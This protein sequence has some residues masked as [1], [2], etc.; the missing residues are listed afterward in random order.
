[1]SK[2]LKSI[3]LFYAAFSFCIAAKAADIDWKAF[4]KRSDPVWT[5]LPEKFDHGAFAG[6]GTLGLTV[7]QENATAMRFAMGRN[8]VTSHVRDNARLQM[9]GLCLA[10]KGKITDGEL[11][12]NLWDAEIHGRIKTEAGTV[13]FTAYV[14]EV[15]NTVIIDY[16]GT[17]GE[18]DCAWEWRPEKAVCSDV[19]YTL[20]DKPNPEWTMD[21]TGEV[22]WCEQKR[23]AGGS[24]TAAWTDRHSRILFT[25]ADTFPNDD[26]RQTAVETVKR[27]VAESPEALLS[28]HRNWWHAYY[29]KAFLS[30]PDSQIEGF[31]WI[32]MYKLASA[33]RPDG[34][35]MDLQGPWNRPTG[36]P[37]IWWNLNIQIAYSPVYAANRLELGESFTRFIDA[38][39]DAFFANAKEIWGFDDCAT[40]PHT[41]SYDARNGTGYCR[42]KFGQYI[43][44]GDFTWAL[45]VYWQQYRYSMDESLVNDHKAHAFYP[46][47]KGSVNLYLRLLQT[48]SDGKLHLPKMHSPE[49][50]NAADNN[51]N[52]S[53]LRWGCTTL[54]SLNERYGI[55]DSQAGD[56]QRVLRDLTPYPQNENGF[57]IGADVP[58]AHSHRHWSHML[59]VWPLHLLSCEQP[60]NKETVQKT[61]RHWLNVD[62]GK[63]IWGWSAAAS[64]HLYAIMGDGNN[65]VKQLRSHHNNKH[66]VMPNTQY[67][68]GS[69]VYECSLVAASS[70]QYMLLQSWGGTIRVFPSVPDEWK[71]ASF[72]NLRAEGAFLVS[73][74]R[75]D[76]RTAWVRV[77]SL[78]GEPCR[79]K[80]NFTGPF[81]CDRPASLKDLGNGV[82]G[83][84]LR[85][86]ESIVLFQ[87]DR[88]PE[89]QPCG[90]EGQPEN[91][92]GVKG[93][94]T[95]VDMKGSL[96]LGKRAAEPSLAKGPFEPTD[97]SLKHYQ[98]PEWFRDAKFGIWAVWGPESVPMHGDWYARRM[99][100]P[101]EEDNEHHL[102]HYGHPSKFGFK[103]IIPLWKAENWN[104]ERLMKL[105]QKAGAKYF[106]MIA[107]HHD[108]FDCWN[109]TFQRW[110]AVNMGPRR[111]IAGEWQKAAQNHG[112][113]FGMTEHLAASWWF[114]SPAKGS[115][116]SEP[117]AGVPYDGADPKYADLYWNGNEKPDGH[118]YLPKAPAF[119]KQIWFNRIKDMVDRYHPDLLY[120]DSPL[121]YPGEFGQK[122][123]A[124]YYNDNIQQ[125]GGKLEAVYNCKQDSQGRW[126]QDLER[127]VMHGINPNPW[128]TDTCVGNWYYQTGC[129]YKSPAIILQMLADI[130]AKNG[131]LLLN[132]PPRP[133]GTLDE[134][135][136]KILAELAAWMPINGEAIFGTRPWPVYGEGP[137]KVKKGANFN[138]GSLKYTARDIRFTT[139]GD[140]LY[141]LA[142]GWPGDG[143]IVVQSLAK[144]AGRI[145][146]VALLGCKDKL[147]WS[148]TDEGLVVT[149][150]K[151]KP[152]E[153]VFALKVAGVNIRPAPLPADLPTVL[154][155]D[156]M[157]HLLLAGSTAEIK[158]ETPEYIAAE[159]QIGFWSNPS[160][161]VCWDISL[162]KAGTYAVKI[163]YSCDHSAGG[164]AFT[165][166]SGGAKLEAISKSTGTWRTHT[167]ET[168]GELSL[169]K[170]KQTLAV[171]PKAKPKW[172]VIGIRSVELQPVNK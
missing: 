80:P 13:T 32:Q 133:D 108:N 102:K 63:Q 95:F 42:E 157:G 66:F 44:P 18:K 155:P 149:M 15:K 161:Y 29:P 79:L 54:L 27:A 121:P 75:K 115:D 3:I 50:G 72:Q 23:T 47:L 124:H 52:L 114:Y 77:E 106:C 83:I 8:D 123:L 30:V 160:D 138:E 85:K 101:G 167:T 86:G 33:M 64:A 162:P 147:V 107:M 2:F 127:G 137:S 4:L 132:F 145:S 22:Q 109:S 59:M 113:R 21:R 142:L 14:H 148:Q 158:G 7:F 156:A 65:A 56:W 135:E 111:D 153:H 104:P 110:N 89:M 140:A 34:M 38:H 171:K 31:Y 60:E 76:D 82:Y 169:A 78:A 139:K 70:L 129:G 51:Y 120:S 24:Y 35:V 90:I 55:H 41:T 5:A 69:P 40:T 116:K 58:L 43:N 36:W 62:N 46:L 128:Q 28:S 98:C 11:R 6:N 170:G 103:D 12:T 39:R 94:L 73:A 166:E 144:A 49:Y 61:L 117:M 154:V 74:I 25:L 122:L 165:V 105:Y 53:L 16:A 134:S 20:G 131:N 141:A 88:A 97:E 92:W 68:E 26:S 168:L 37:R 151:Q 9:G 146:D 84:D 125:H 112:M 45:W 159:D 96:S 1:M 126:V 67:I 17:G 152:C 19:R 118:Y 136:E 100:I 71:T 87:G 99:Y 143:K 119:V 48:A 130:V 10:T 172:K 164:S 57:M 163:T 93:P 150:P 81:E 91:V